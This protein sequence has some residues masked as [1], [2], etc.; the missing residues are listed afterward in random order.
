[1]VERKRLEIGAMTMSKGVAAKM[2]GAEGRSPFV[3]D[4]LTAMARYIASD[5]GEVSEEDRQTNEKAIEH[6]GR[7]FASYTADGQKVWVI[8][9]ADR[10]STAILFPEEY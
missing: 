5:W 3:K 1:M 6:G 4:V 10:K 7:V 9:E 8:T 2:R